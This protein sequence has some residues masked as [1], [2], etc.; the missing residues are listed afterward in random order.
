[1]RDREIEKLQSA[2]AELT[3]K[4]AS[5][6]PDANTKR[7]RYWAIQ[8]AELPRVESKIAELEVQLQ[9]SLISV[10]E[11]A[12]EAVKA[13]FWHRVEEL[14]G[15]HAGIEAKREWLTRAKMDYEA[16]RDALLSERQDLQVYFDAG[17]P[18]PSPIPPAVP[19]R[20]S[21][22]SLETIDIEK[23][24]NRGGLTLWKSKKHST[25]SPHSRLKSWHCIGA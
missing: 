5:A 21:H 12:V 4:A 11:Q 15:L 3:A 19:R 13:G 25:G 14:A 6:E 22:R 16:Q 20:K 7:Q 9:N 23:L 17:A 10:E 8:T 2:A 24:C 18:L 1:M